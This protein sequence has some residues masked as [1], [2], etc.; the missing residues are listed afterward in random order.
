MP[1]A[2][3]IGPSTEAALAD[4]APRLRPSDV[5]EVQAAMGW[6]PLQALVESAAVSVESYV[7]FV[8]G[9]PAAAWGVQPVCQAAGVGIVW[10]LGSDL[11]TQHPKAFFQLCVQERDRMLMGWRCLFNWIDARYDVSVRWAHRLG[12][13]VDP[14]QPFGV[15]G[16]P[17]CCAAIVR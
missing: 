17:F 6:S 16:M 11:I 4:L 2:Y 12:C 7:W 3:A 5:A 8:D 14:P 1:A 9:V 13:R 15:N 10:L